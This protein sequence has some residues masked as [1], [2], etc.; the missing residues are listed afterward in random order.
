MRFNLQFRKLSVSNPFTIIYDVTI[1]HRTMKI[2]L[3]KRSNQRCSLVF[4]TVMLILLV[5][6]TSVYIYCHGL[7]KQEEYDVIIY[8]ATPAGFAAAL[9]AKESGAETVLIIEPTSHVG[10]MASPGGIGLRDC[11]RNDIRTN[12][13][14]QYMWAMRNAEYYDITEPV[15]QPDNW[16]GELSFLEMLDDYDVELRLNT[17]FVEG[18]D[19]VFT[20][21]SSDGL[22]RITGILLESREKLRCKYFIDASYEGEVMMATGAVSYTHGR[23]HKNTYNESFGGISE[24]SVAE[25]KLIIDPYFSDGHVRT[26]LKWIQDGSDPWDCLGEDDDN[27]MAYSFRVC[28]TNNASNMVPISKPPGYEPMDFELP[29]RYVIEEIAAG[30]ELIRPWDNLEYHGYPPNKTMKYDACCGYAPVGIDA[31]G[32]AV[33]YPVANRAQQKVIY[34]EHKYYVQGLMWFWA[35]DPAVPEYIRNEINKLG[36]CKDEWPNNG[37]FPPQLYVREAVRMIGDQ[38]YTQNDRINSSHENGCRTDSIAI[39]SWGFDIHEMQRVAVTDKRMSQQAI[40]NEGLTEPGMG[41]VVMFEIPYYIVLPKRKEMVNLAVPNCPSVSHVAFSAICKE[42]TLWQLGQAAGTAAGIAISRGG[43]IP[44]QDIP[45]KTLQQ[46]LLD[47]NTF[48]HWP[49]GRTN[50]DDPL[51]DF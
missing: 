4:L 44:L 42:P 48:I 6:L 38:V 36:L 20:S 29:R 9:A 41:G 39:G 14:T 16:V 24:G 10:G 5:S 32:L 21:V 28:L 45:P 7:S 43:R 17:N 15:W 50:C 35:N 13:S 19:G 34:D 49:P 51:P 40:F 31:V 12:N 22:R 11:S 3:S 27:V 33:D 8:A 23:E 1:F 47:Q 30:M 2:H 37:H 26:L 46:Y 18:S 25:F